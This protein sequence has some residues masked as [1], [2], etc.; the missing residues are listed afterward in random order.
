MEFWR[1]SLDML[2]SNKWKRNPH[3]CNLRNKT[4]VVLFQYQFKNSALIQDLF[5]TFNI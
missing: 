2:A 5:C 1:L 3:I 4:E